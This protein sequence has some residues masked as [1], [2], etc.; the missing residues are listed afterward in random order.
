MRYL[1]LLLLTACYGFVPYGTECEPDIV[2]GYVQYVAAECPEVDVGDAVR[3]FRELWESEHPRGCGL[4]LGGSWSPQEGLE[5]REGEPGG[6]YPP[7]VTEYHRFRELWA[8]DV[9][10]EDVCMVGRWGINE[11]R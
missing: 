2:R 4:D 9:D 8:V 1:P 3:D 5:F 10:G 11:W 7:G 6:S